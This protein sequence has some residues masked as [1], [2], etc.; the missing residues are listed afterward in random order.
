MVTTTVSEEIVSVQA[1]EPVT[2][3]AG[4][5][6]EARITVVVAD[7]YHIQAN[8]A[9]SE[10]FVPTRLQLRARGGISSKEPKY[11]SGRPYRLPGMPEEFMTYEEAIVVA[12]TLVAGE[13]A[14]PGDRLLQGSL[15]YQACDDRSCLFPASVPVSVPVRVVTD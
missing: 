1:V 14:Q 6:A 7:G 4:Q 11:P 12:I 2:L 5:E 15:R 3:A 9:S 8:P 13:L 10:F